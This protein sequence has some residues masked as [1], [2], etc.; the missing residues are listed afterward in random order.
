VN[1]I[2]R[3]LM[4]RRQA[5]IG[6]TA[7][8][9][10]R[11]PTMVARV[12]K[13]TRPEEVIT[14][15]YLA[16]TKGQLESL[17]TAQPGPVQRVPLAKGGTVA[18]RY[19]GRLNAHHVFAVNGDEIMERPKGQGGSMDFV[20]AGNPHKWKNIVPPDTRFVDWNQA[21]HEWAPDLLHED[22]E[23]TLMGAPLHLPY[24]H[25]HAFMNGVEK[26]YRH[27]LGIGTTPP[28]GDGTD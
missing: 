27:Q 6:T 22:G 15:A 18:G 12:R 11:Q 8:P 19:L 20:I 10:V 25:A 3:Y 14:P 26:H 4:K 7:V 9:H 23:D 28:I 1:S 13:P 5:T 24:E 21:H 17:R 16:H 2:K